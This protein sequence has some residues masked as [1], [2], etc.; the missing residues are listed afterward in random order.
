MTV[1]V[2][3]VDDSAVIRG[4]IARALELDS[5]LEIVMTAANGRMAVQMAQQV[6][7]DVVVLDIEMPEMD[8]MAALPEILKVSPKTKIIMA[9]TL[10]ERNAAI[11][12]E[13]LARGASDY[14][15]KPS[16]RDKSELDQFYYEL[17]NKTRALGGLGIASTPSTEPKA[18]TVSQQ[19]LIGPKPHAQ[20]PD[21]GY[22]LVQA[23]TKPVHALAIASST[24]GPQALLAVMKGLTGRL[25]HIPIFLTQHM[26]PTFTT[27]LAEQITRTGERPS[28][29]AREGEVVQNGSMYVAPG[30]YHLVPRREGV[31]VLLHLNQD[32][33]VNF[34]RPAA[35][36]MISALSDIYREGL[37]TVV[38]TGMGND[39]QA[40]ARIARERGGSVIAQDEA[41]SVVWG[42]PKAAAEAGICEAVLPLDKIAP[43]IIKR[44]EG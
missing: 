20:Q 33:P 1:R 12:L 38:L 21:V 5:E 28:A 37:L 41:T 31:Q 26:P 29:E 16:A 40:G 18:G 43:Y 27:L 3:L 6:K 7:P 25:R 17:R 22:T 2:M 32:P 24:G 11:S 35:D 19:A 23:Q 9:S 44:C 36:P 8:G 30:N 15:A 13:A 39:G 10:T 14:V 34:C 4:L 42:M